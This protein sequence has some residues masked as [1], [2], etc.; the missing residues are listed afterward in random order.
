MSSSISFAG[1]ASAATAP[2]L[3]WHSAQKSK[4]HPSLQRK[5]SSSGSL[6]CEQPS[7]TQLPL[8]EFSRG[9]SCLAG[10]G[11]GR[12]IMERSLVATP[13]LSVATRKANSGS[14]P[15]AR[16]AS[17]KR[18]P[19]GVIAASAARQASASPSQKAT[20]VGSSFT[21]LTSC[22]TVPTG[23]GCHGKSAPV[24]SP[25]MALRPSLLMTEPSL[26]RM[27]RLGMPSTPKWLLSTSFSLRC[28]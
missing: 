16:A 2:A 11:R 12:P 10:G 17:L 9:C 26:S 5:R 21:M 27:T 18:S 20:T 7:Q 8:A 19:S 23:F 1:F 4:S 24:G 22:A 25:L 13:P 14:S 3:A 28:E 6:L 15:E